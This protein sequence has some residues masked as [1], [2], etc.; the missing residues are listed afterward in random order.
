MDI[1]SSRPFHSKEL[2]HYLCFFFLIIPRIT[3]FFFPYSKIW[4]TWH[5]LKETLKFKPNRLSKITIRMALKQCCDPI[6]A[7]IASNCSGPGLAGGFHYKAQQ[8]EQIQKP[9]TMIMQNQK[10]KL[11]STSP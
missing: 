3:T 11:L 7:S 8:A 1:L 6:V 5:Q 4:K 10:S 9:I 2:T